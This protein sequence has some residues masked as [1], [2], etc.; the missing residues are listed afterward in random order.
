M[1]LTAAGPRVLVARVGGS[2][3]AWPPLRTALED[4]LRSR[5]HRRVVLIAGGGAVV[6]EL[7]ALDRIHHLGEEAAHRL[8]L[9]ALELTAHLLAATVP[10]LEVVD[11]FE[12][13][14]AVWDAGG[15]PVLSPRRVLDADDGRPGALE[16]TWRVTS[17]SIAAR[18]AVLLRGELILLKSAP[19]PDGLD[20]AGAARLGLVDEAFPEAARPLDRVRFQ[21]L[22]DP[23]AAPPVPLP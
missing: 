15:V 8:A 3:L 1:D 20:R 17:D 6:D 2:L 11:R 4:W 21:N 5:A 22:R 10:G 16:H 23:G 7:R 9:R 19:A 12:A 18:V 13:L 14:P